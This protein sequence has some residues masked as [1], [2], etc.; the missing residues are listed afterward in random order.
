MV[1][2]G[3]MEEL[4]RNWVT[5]PAQTEGA[6]NAATGV[7]ATLIVAVTVSGQLLPED[8]IKV[9]VTGPGFVNTTFGFREV[10]KDGVPPGIDH[11]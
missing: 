1:S 10:L 7:A 5:P 2:P 3:D 9:M 11:V 6:E 8:A 4:F